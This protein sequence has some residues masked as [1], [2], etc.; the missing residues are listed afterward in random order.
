M[1]SRHHH[2]PL[3]DPSLVSAHPE[4]AERPPAAGIP[5]TP[6]FMAAGNI[7]LQVSVRVSITGV[8]IVIG[9]VLASIGLLHGLP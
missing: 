2:R 7:T 3:S 6:Q 9:S 1:A 8:V 4:P 5:S